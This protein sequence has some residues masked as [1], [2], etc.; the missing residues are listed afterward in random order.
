[1]NRCS[2]ARETSCRREADPCSDNPRMAQGKR[3]SADIPASVHVY[4]ITVNVQQPGA[5][6]A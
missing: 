2:F 3:I 6:A 4:G 5:G 1:M